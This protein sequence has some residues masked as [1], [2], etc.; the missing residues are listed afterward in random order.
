MLQSEKKKYIINIEDEEIKKLSRHKFESLVENKANIFAFQYL[1][2][3]T[4]RY[5]KLDKNPGSKK[6]KNT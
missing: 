2:N 5:S 1:K 6:M 3:I 4:S